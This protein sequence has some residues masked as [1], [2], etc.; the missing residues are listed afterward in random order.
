[1]LEL[2]ARGITPDQFVKVV[3]RGLTPQ[4]AEQKEKELI[5]HHKP[6]RLM[7]NTQF[8]KGNVRPHRN[9]SFPEGP[10]RDTK[11]THRR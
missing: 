2:Q 11:G 10:Q 4:K 9:R 6:E 7:F 1:M 5:A 8:N 3:F